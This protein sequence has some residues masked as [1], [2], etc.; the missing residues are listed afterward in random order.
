MSIYLKSKT[1]NCTTQR[2]LQVN[3]FKSDQSN[4]WLKENPLLSEGFRYLAKSIIWVVLHVHCKVKSIYRVSEE[5]PP[6]T[7]LTMIRLQVHKIPSRNVYMTKR[8]CFWCGWK[9]YLPLGNR[10]VL[11]SSRIKTP[12]R[13]IP[14]F[15]G[16]H[17]QN[18]NGAALIPVHQPCLKWQ[19]AIVYQF[20]NFDRVEVG[21]PL[22][23][24][25]L[26]CSCTLKNNTSKNTWF[27]NGWKIIPVKIHGSNG[28]E[29]SLK[30][31]MVEAVSK[32]FL[33]NTKRYAFFKTF[34][35]NNIVQGTVV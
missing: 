27:S 6:I 34:S 21:R 15:P 19:P 20:S 22:T 1:R 13:V 29:L 2:L 12:I 18:N 16:F 23:A 24:L 31:L 5:I 9:L 26:S 25:L 32:Q 33:S 8:G 3:S 14:L 11:N 30:L 35:Q 28:F 10:G 4:P 17:Q 7:Q